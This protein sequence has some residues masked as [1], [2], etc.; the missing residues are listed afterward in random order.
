MTVPEL[1]AYAAPVSFV[2][3][4]AKAA[5]SDVASMKIGNRLILGF[6]AAYV[7]LAALSGLAF[8]QL[9]LSAGVAAAVLAVGFLIFAC[10]WMGG[11]D[12][13]LA[14]ATALWLGPEATPAY[15]VYT[16]L[17]GGV[18]TLMMLQLRKLPLPSGVREAPWAQRLHAPD[19]GV[20]YGVALAIAAV[21]AFP[22]SH[23][24][25]GFA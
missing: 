7:V 17:A 5:V 2:F 20:P 24:F 23:W 22:K 10:G 16:A 1:A 9:A 13:K 15:L 21:L 18:L 12:V 4:T 6:V 19:M 11:G 14:A 3:F 25:S 8:N